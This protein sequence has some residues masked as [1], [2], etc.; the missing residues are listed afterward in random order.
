M[1]GAEVPVERTPAGLKIV[2]PPDALYVAVE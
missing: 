1:P 2:L